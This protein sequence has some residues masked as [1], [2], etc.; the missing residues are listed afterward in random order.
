MEA[1][2][3]GSADRHRL[4]RKRTVRSCDTCRK[5]KVKCDR[6]KP[7]QLCVRYQYVCIYSNAP[8]L[9]ASKP[10]SRPI[11][12][13]SHASGSSAAFPNTR[14][15]GNE[16]HRELRAG[17]SAF[18]SETQAYQF[19]GPS[20]YFS[21]VQR[22]HQRILRQ[23][24]KP[25]MKMHKTIPEGLQRWGVHRQ[26]FPNHKEQSNIDCQISE[27]SILPRD[28]G[29]DFIRKYFTIMHPQAPILDEADV[30]RI[31][32]ELFEIKR[33]T[34][35]AMQQAATER[36]ILYMVLAIGA[37]LSDRCEG[38]SCELWAELYFERACSSSEPVHETSL[39]SCHVLVL[40][41]IYSM[42]ISHTNWIY[43]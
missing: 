40:K 17:I 37:C 23:S 30:S 27:G 18:N 9:S 10:Q 13:K 16:K 35:T 14:S 43:L 32:G 19:Y 26:M 8:H 2:H 38:K 42:Q 1:E 4:D 34:Q 12:S 22:L 6:N 24:N 36:S 15:D 28:L 11:Q 25:M 20:S 5:R 31:W 3:S 33:Y 7:C 29:D 21:F 39:G 41:A